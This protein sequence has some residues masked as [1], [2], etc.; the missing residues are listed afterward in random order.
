MDDHKEFY[1]EVGRR[2]R[3]ARK[4]RLLT[5]ESLASL[6]SLT[7]TS[8]TNI[9]KGRQKILL[10]TLADLA[11]A[12]RVNYASLLPDN[13]A[14]SRDTDLQDALKGRPLHEQQ[15]IKSAVQSVREG[16]RAYASPSKTHTVVGRAAS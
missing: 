13:P 14:R 3:K 12:L 2:V 16:E 11:T 7:R 5:Q 1:A 9:E 8:I 4:S 15:F 10:H 6:V